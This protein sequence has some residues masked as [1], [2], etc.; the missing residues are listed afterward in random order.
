MKALGLRY[1]RQRWKPAFDNKIPQKDRKQHPNLYQSSI[2]NFDKSPIEILR[3]EVAE[4]SAPPFYPYP[5]GLPQKERHSGKEKSAD[6]NTKG[7]A[8]IR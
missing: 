7:M 1:I 4:D 6:T 8:K 2:E 5:R 3:K